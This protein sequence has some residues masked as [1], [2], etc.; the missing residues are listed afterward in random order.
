MFAIKRFLN[1]LF[2]VIAV[3]WLRYTF[4][5][6]SNW[7]FYSAFLLSLIT[8]NTWPFKHFLM[9]AFTGSMMALL[10]VLAS[11][12]PF[13]TAIPIATL[14][15]IT[16]ICTLLMKKYRQYGYPLFIINLTFIIAICMP[17]ASW[18]ENMMHSGSILIG[19][20]IAIV[21]QL[22]FIIHFKQDQ[23]NSWF[24]IALAAL[25]DLTKDVFS[26]FLQPGYKEN[27]YLFEHHLHDAKNKFLQAL[28]QLRRFSGKESEAKIKK[29]ENLFTILLDCSQLRTR[30][31]DFT[32]FDVCKTDLVAIEKTMGELLKNIR[33]QGVTQKTQDAVVNPA[34]S[35]TNQINQFENTYQT[36]LRVTALE[37]LVFLLFILDLKTFAEVLD[38]L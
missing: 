16:F 1:L 10:M 33:N 35:L 18:P 26:C 32:I 23:A 3:F 27:Q 7:L 4:A 17:A 19:T 5:I 29:L 34:A 21:G 24:R 13:G 8:F 20:I 31:S 6:E 30:V 2:V 11:A 37:P 14:F 36:V 12:M 22:L 28:Y 15:L 9:M 25:E 38:D